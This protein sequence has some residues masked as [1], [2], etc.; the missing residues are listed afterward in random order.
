MNY[1][2]LVEQF[3]TWLLKLFNHQVMMVIKL[4]FG[5][6]ELYYIFL[7]QDVIFHYKLDLPF[8]DDNVAVLLENI[9][10]A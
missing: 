9:I 4:I 6:W 8:E 7:V 10:T 2:P 5:H 1:I 3:I